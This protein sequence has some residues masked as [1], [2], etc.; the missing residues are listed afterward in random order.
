MVLNVAFL[1]KP[2]ISYCYFGVIGIWK[3]S[4]IKFKMLKA[5]VLVREHITYMKH[6]KIQWCHMGVI[7]MPK[8]LICKM[9]Q[10]AH[11]LSLIMHFYSANMYWGVVTTVHVSI[12]LTKKQIKT[13][14]NNT[15]YWVSY[16][17]YHSTSYCPW[18]DSIKKRINML[19]V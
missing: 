14:R 11:I 16:L 7:F 3:N 15:L 12:F 4:K 9:L 18:Y 19:H 10:C 8:H 5:E 13:W 17:S 2:H 6:I 1:L